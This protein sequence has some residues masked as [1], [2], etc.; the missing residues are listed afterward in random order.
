M[1]GHHYHRN[2]REGRSDILK[3]LHTT[4]MRHVQIENNCIKIKP[5]ILECLSNLL[6][7][8]EGLNGI[9]M[10]LKRRH[11]QVANTGLVVH[12]NDAF[13]P[14]WK[15]FR[16]IRINRHFVPLVDRQVNGK[17]RSLSY[18]T[19]QVDGSIVVVN[20]S[21][22]DRESQSRATR[23]FFGRIK[24]FKDAGDDLLRHS[25]SRVGHFQADI[26]ELACQVKVGDA[27]AE[28]TKCLQPQLSAVF[29]GVAGVH[30]EVHDNLLY[31]RGIGGNWR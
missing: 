26:V 6:S 7:I 20:N 17:G 16:L 10:G 1:A 21:I 22:D 9:S 2:L 8:S 27:S 25:D 23:F 12:D 31:L 30:T 24:R 29:H 18:R 5:T 11:Q 13:R 15:V 3:H 14:A 4:H 28:N 19:A